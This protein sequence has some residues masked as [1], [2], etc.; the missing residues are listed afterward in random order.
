MINEALEQAEERAMRYEER[1]DRILCRI[2]SHYLINQ[3]LEDAL[4]GAREAMNE[5]RDFA[6]TLRSLQME[7]IC[8]F[9][10]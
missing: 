2:S 7:L 6:V 5:A 9:P 10:Y 4:T 1:H 8:S 3:D